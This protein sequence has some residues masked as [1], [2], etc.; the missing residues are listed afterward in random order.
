MTIIGDLY[1]QIQT[2]DGKEAEQQVL[3]ISTAN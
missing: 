1:L 2:N 3:N